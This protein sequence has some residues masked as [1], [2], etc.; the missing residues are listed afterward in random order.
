MLARNPGLHCAV[1]HGVCMYARAT[2]YGC[3]RRDDPD[4]QP[5]SASPGRQHL[6]SWP[7]EPRFSQS[8]F[9]AR[10]PRDTDTDWCSEPCLSGRCRR[11]CGGGW[12]RVAGT[13]VTI[14]VLQPEFQVELLVC[15]GLRVV[16]GVSCSASVTVKYGG[17]A[18]TSCRHIRARDTTTSNTPSCGN[19]RQ[20]VHHTSQHRR[21][22]D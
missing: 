8:C 20:P 7:P 11:E 9:G 4:R 6:S 12:E 19:L 18:R 1:G 17:G 13:T 22:V 15:V 2:A 5:L 16:A 10:S 14:C 21:G 3:R